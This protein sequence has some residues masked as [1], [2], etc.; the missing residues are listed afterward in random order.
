MRKRRSRRSTDSTRCT[1]RCIAADVLS[2]AYETMPPEPGGTGCGRAD[3]RRHRGVRA[4]AVA[5]RTGPRTEG[6]RRIVRRRCGGCG[7][8]RRTANSVPWGFPRSATV[9]CKWRRSWSSSRSLTRTCSRSNTPTEPTTA[10]TRRCGRCKACSWIAAITEV[11][12]ADL[13]GYF[14]SIPHHELMKCVAR[15]ISDGTSAASGEDVAGSTGRG[16]GRA[17]EGRVRTTRNKDDGRGTPQGGV[18]VAA[19]GESVHAAVRAGLEGKRT[20]SGVWMLTSST[21]QTTS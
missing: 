1:T 10:P 8:P 20:G 21:M 13:S 16:N 7:F 2:E 12:D 14:D 11:V 5:G 17:G 19:A 4:R 9:W 15:R 6:A 3:V 18:A